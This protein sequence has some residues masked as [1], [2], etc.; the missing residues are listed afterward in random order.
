[1][2]YVYL[3]TAIDQNHLASHAVIQWPINFATMK[4][5]VRQQAAAKDVQE[6]AVRVLKQ[7]AEQNGDGPRQWLE[8]KIMPTD[9]PLVIETNFPH[10]L[11]R[12]IKDT[13]QILENAAIKDH[14]EENSDKSQAVLDIV[15]IMNVKVLEKIHNYHGE[16]YI[17]KHRPDHSKE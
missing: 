15:K 13:M 5:T 9:L 10:P 2:S 17:A 11:V 8:L 7:F 6:E 3:I 14:E 4:D 12:D 16:E 1:M